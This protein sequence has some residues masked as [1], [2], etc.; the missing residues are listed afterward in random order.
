MPRTTPCPAQHGFLTQYDRPEWQPLIDVVGERLTG[1]FMWMQENELEDGTAVHA[2]K[3][4]HT[5]DYLY[6]SADGRAFEI[7]PCERYVRLRTDVAIERAL[8]PWWMLRG[9][10]PDDVEAIRAAI[11]RAQGADERS[12]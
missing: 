2:Y 12:P 1:T 6:L 10:E 7:T 11:L 9:W 5:R 4:I 8:C 3:H